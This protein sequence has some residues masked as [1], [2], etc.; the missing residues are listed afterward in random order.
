MDVADKCR[1]KYDEWLA[2][3]INYVLYMHGQLSSNQLRLK[4]R[5]QVA[6]QKENMRKQQ[7]DADKNSG[8]TPSES[9]ITVTMDQLQEWDWIERK[10][11][12]KNTVTGKGLP[13][14]YYSLS[15]QARFCTINDILPS[16][17]FMLKDLYQMILRTAATGIYSV[18]WDSEVGISRLSRTIGT[19][20][21][22]IYLKRDDILLANFKHRNYLRK[23]VEYVFDYTIK[24][25]I[26]RKEMINNEIRYIINPLLKEFVNT[27]W[28]TLYFS[29]LQLVRST[30][31]LNG[32]KKDPNNKFLYNWLKSLNSKDHVENILNECR[33]ERRK[34]SKQE[35]NETF[36]FVKDRLLDIARLKDNLVASHEKNTGETN[37]IDLIKTKESVLYHVCPDFILESVKNVIESKSK[38]YSS[39]KTRKTRSQQGNY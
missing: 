5:Q 25:D 33:Q 12:A 17:S 27:A 7:R 24:K 31:I 20:V 15:E 36:R 14:V 16:E 18:I 4:I 30:F 28:K 21:E 22:D 26:I 19:T 32:F 39:S 9:K 11:A 38:K 10:E 2:L 1:Y 35:F 13:K 29:T 37:P 3:H 8:Y 34:Y 6:N 23:E